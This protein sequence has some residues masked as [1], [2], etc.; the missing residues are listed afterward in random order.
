MTL[1]R[2]ALLVAPGGAYTGG[3][4]APGAH[5]LGA[6]AEYHAGPLTAGTPALLSD[7][8]TPA[9]PRDGRGAALLAGA[10]AAVPLAGN[11]VFTGLIGG[12]GPGV[13]GSG[14]G[15]VPLAAGTAEGAGMSFGDSAE[16]AGEG[17]R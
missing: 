1:P 12:R 11:G 6:R 9:L 2:R 10:H 14:R 5:A 7:I 15:L 4:Y 13:L 8:S 17:F 3:T 16:A